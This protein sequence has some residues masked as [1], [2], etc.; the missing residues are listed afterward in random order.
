M[1]KRKGRTGKGV[2]V[3]KQTELKNGTRVVSHH[4]PHMDSV[5]LGIWI[6]AGGR[7]ETKAKAGIYHFIEHLLFDGTKKRS[8]IEIKQA[9]EGVGGSLNGFTG[10]EF[11]CYLVKMLAKHYSL[12]LDVLSDMVLN[13][14]FKPKNIIK[15]K[16]VIA[17][18]IRMY[19][20][21]PAH[22]AVELLD[23][24]LWPGHPLGMNLA[25]TVKSVNSMTIQD[26]Q[27]YKRKAYTPAN[28]AVVATGAL[29][30]EELVD[31]VS[32]FFSKT[33]AGKRLQFKPANIK[34][35][36][37]RHKLHFKQTEQTHIALGVH[38]V[39]HL[40][41]DRFAVSLLHIILGANMSSRL[42]QEIREKRG[43]AYAISTHVKK[44]KDAGAFLVTAGVRNEK[45]AEALEVTLKM[46]KKIKQKGVT[47]NE[48]KRAKDYYLGQ[49]L[50]ALEDTAEHMI[51]MGEQLICI[52]RIFSAQQILKKVNA[53]TK[54]DLSRLAGQ[55]FRAENLNL[56]VV[57]P[58]KEKVKSK[59]TGA[60]DI[61]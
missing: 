9:I 15:E 29:K 43:L 40:D 1:L 20:D 21:L 46:L 52:D 41:P 4:M 35:D 19:N 17:E 3:Y 14:V 5:A 22:Y 59:L 56:A 13:A 28:I 10:E 27:A 8:G 18:E 11:T 37:P 25:G 24:L 49:L 32:R 44:H 33:A 50:M 30:H 45:A 34:Q 57:G 26:I 53:V 61:L 38:G 42:F 12:G 31:S 23:E 60:L 54:E 55:L 48:L 39:S 58:L 51:W 7:Y 47:A 16:G 36:K 2:C 6:A